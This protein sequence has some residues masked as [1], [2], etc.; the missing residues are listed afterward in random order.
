MEMGM[1]EIVADF[2]IPP[3]RFGPRFTLPQISEFLPQ[4]NLYLALSLINTT[5]VNI[6]IFEIVQ[7]LT[8]LSLSHDLTKLL[9]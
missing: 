9:N 8:I 7:I 6:I 5:E 4:V 1:G 3:T 2:V